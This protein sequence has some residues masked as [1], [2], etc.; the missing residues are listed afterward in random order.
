MSWVSL[1]CYSFLFLSLCLG[2]SAM[3]VNLELSVSATETITPSAP[4]WMFATSLMLISEYVYNKRVLVLLPLPH[5]MSLTLT[6]SLDFKNTSL[7]LSLLF[8]RCLAFVMR[9]HNVN[10]RKV[11]PLSVLCQLGLCHQA[12]R[13]G[14]QR[15]DKCHY[16]HSIIELKIWRVQ[17]DTGMVCT[18][19]AVEIV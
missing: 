16:A 7:S 10:Y 3:T 17:Q 12:I 9:A 6:L 11:R 2:R 13:Y 14:C 5:L 19:C 8:V 18:L 1:F 15:E 4:T